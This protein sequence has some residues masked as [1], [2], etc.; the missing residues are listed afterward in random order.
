MKERHFVNSMA[1]QVRS[2]SEIKE[3][4][5]IYCTIAKACGTGTKDFDLGSLFEQHDLV[6][7]NEVELHLGIVE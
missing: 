1:V 3:R 5:R 2:K 4:P 6:N 7:G